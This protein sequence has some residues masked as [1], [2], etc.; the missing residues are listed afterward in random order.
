MAVKS[1]WAGTT[2]HRRFSTRK[3][4]RRDRDVFVSDL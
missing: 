1:P 2:A 3:R 4:G